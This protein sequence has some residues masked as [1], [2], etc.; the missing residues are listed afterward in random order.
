MA[1]IPEMLRRVKSLGLERRITTIIQ[2]TQP[3]AVKLNQ[4]QLFLKGEDSE[5][6]KLKYLNPTY[7]IDKNK[8]NPLPGLF[9]ADL[10]VTGQF[11][12]GFYAQVK[13]GKS[14]IFGSTDSK[15][16]KLEAQFGSKIFGLTKENKKVYAVQFVKRELFQQITQVTGLRFK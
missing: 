15:S 12:R 16:S 10:F 4:N 2:N 7:A 1:T 13:G 14:I 3:D 6:N 5:G 9:N 8:L 11:Y